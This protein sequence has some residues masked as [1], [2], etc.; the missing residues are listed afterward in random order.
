M[1]H[2]TMGGKE[3][4]NNKVKSKEEQQSWRGFLDGV[5]NGCMEL[6]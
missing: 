2:N 1:T 5:V 3:R 4:G 6:R